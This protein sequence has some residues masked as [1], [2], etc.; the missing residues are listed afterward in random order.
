MATGTFWGTVTNKLTSAALNNAAGNSQQFDIDLATNNWDVVA[1]QVDITLGT[2]TSVDVEF[3]G[4]AD[5]T[6]FDAI[7][8]PGSYSQTTSGQRTVPVGMG[9]AA[10]RCIIT[11]ND[12]TD[13]GSVTA[14]IRGRQWSSSV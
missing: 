14:N 1:S 4:S 10:I 11:D 12:A 6:N 7:A 8:L 3:F 9:Y 13:D 5:G 2:S